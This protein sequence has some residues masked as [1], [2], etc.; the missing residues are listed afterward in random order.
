ME[1]LAG[2]IFTLFAGAIIYKWREHYLE[3]QDRKAR[4]MPQA[5]RRPPIDPTDPREWRDRY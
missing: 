5:T 1:F 4:E 3:R 2:I